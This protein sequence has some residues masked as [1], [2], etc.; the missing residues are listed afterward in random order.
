MRRAIELIRNMLFIVVCV[1]AL[2]L[3]GC[4]GDGFKERSI[5]FSFSNA[6]H[7]TVTMNDGMVCL[8]T[9]SESVKLISDEFSSHTYVKL[10]DIVKNP[11]GSKAVTWP[12]S[13]SEYTILW[14]DV[15]SNNL[16]TVYILEP[17]GYIIGYKGHRN[18]VGDDL[19][20]DI[21]GW[22]SGKCHHSRV[23]TRR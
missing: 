14:E 10:R 16:D 12:S 22:P 15:N 4:S 20:I 23:K 3:V 18:K 17:N 13:H 5:K 9:D 8:I 11:D 7:I 19:N 21:H 6:D 1:A 2:I